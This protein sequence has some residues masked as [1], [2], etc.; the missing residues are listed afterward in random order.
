LNN[1]LIYAVPTVTYAQMGV[2]ILSK[3]GFRATVERN[4]AGKEGC[5][6]I[7]VV[8]SRNA[9]AVEAALQRGGV[10]VKRL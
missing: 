8:N 6:F 5:G 7:I 2:G 10:Q 3:A 9:A 4:H 1:T